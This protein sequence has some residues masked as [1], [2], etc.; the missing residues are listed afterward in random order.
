MLG[1]GGVSKFSLIFAKDDKN[2]IKL[3]LFKDEEVCSHPGGITLRRSGYYT[4]PALAEIRPDK[5][6]NCLVEGFTIGR[7]GYGNIHYPGVTNI[8]GTIFN[9]RLKNMIFEII[10][11]LSI[12][13]T[14]RMLLR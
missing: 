8:A 13:Y 5:D 9:V 10:S 7:E 6:G 2:F 12:L 11:S 1:G 4:I 3:K 14:N